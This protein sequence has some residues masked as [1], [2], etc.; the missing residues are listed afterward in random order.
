[1]LSKS[2]AV[3]LGASGGVGRELV[4]QLCK[5]E[6]FVR[7]IRVVRSEP[8]KD[9]KFP[10]KAVSHVVE[11]MEKL[12]SVIPEAIQ[13][14][15][16]EQDEAVVGFSVLGVGSATEKISY[17]EHKAV[18]VGLNKK[19]AKGLESSKR[20]DHLVFMSALGA[21]ANAKNEG[22]GAAGTPRYSLVKGESEEAV[23]SAGL[24]YVSIFEPGF[25]ID[26]PHTRSHYKVLLPIV[27]P[28]LPAK[29]KSI[30]VADLA[31]GMAIRGAQ[32]SPSNPDKV[33]I[34]PDI[35]ELLQSA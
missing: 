7:V 18:D 2:T 21:D 11:D 16:T 28:F 6:E 31:K 33:F 34:Y 29:Y 14:Y 22:S 19:F 32:K 1:M 20:C 9:E 35:H 4:E 24:K 26:I 23:K 15:V 13:K 5:R 17:E 27:N 12:E 8:G 25:I 3:V 10:E 30:W